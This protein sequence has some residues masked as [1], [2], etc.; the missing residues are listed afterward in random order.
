MIES[1]WESI[2]GYCKLENKVALGIV[3]GLS[4]KIRVI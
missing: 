4:N 3:K 2:A 1:R